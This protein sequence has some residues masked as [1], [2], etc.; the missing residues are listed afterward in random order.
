LVANTLLA[1]GY[2]PIWQDIFETSNDDL[3]DLLRKKIDD[4]S[5]VMQIVGNAYGAEPPTVDPAYGRIS[6][7]V[8][9]PDRAFSAGTHEGALLAEAGDFESAWRRH[10]LLDKHPDLSPEQRDRLR[11]FGSYLK[12]ME[13]KAGKRR[14]GSDSVS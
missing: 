3:R 1:L 6:G 11:D 7:F 4:C 9:D 10:H 14:D 12:Y 5:A 8:R 13:A 2:E